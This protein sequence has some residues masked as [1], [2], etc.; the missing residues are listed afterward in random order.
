MSFLFPA[1][2]LTIWVNGTRCY[3][4]DAS[5]AHRL[6]GEVQLAVCS[7][8]AY[9][10]L[11]EVL[12]HVNPEALLE[13]TEHGA[14]GQSQ[15]QSAAQKEAQAHDQRCAQEGAR[16]VR[17]LLVSDAEAEAEAAAAP[18]PELTLGG[19]APQGPAPQEWRER[20]VFALCSELLPLVADVCQS[21]AKLVEFW[22]LFTSCAGGRARFAAHC[23]ARLAALGRVAWEQERFLQ[24]RRLPPS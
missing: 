21:G 13:G 20:S 12:P 18:E 22:G 3:R 14:A 1:G 10:G 4:S 6:S 24:V 5:K 11:F 17:A 19:G 15:S 23:L 2:H 7:N 8:T 9:S 16:L